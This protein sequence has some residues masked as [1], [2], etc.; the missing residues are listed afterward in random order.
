LRLFLLFSR[1]KLAGREFALIASLLLLAQLHAHAQTAV[2]ATLPNMQVG[3]NSVENKS[4]QSW[5]SLN[6][7]QQQVLS[8][9]ASEWDKLSPTR[10]KKWLELRQLKN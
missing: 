1:F 3:A 7:T 9:L 8:P 4:S 5:Q 10:Q 6:K 2:N